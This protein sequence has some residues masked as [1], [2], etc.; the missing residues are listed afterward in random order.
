MKRRFTRVRFLLLALLS[1]VVLRAA[2]APQVDVAGGNDRWTQRVAHDWAPRTAAALAALQRV[3]AERYGVELSD[4]QLH[5]VLQATPHAVVPG[6]LG[7]AILVEAGLD[8][9]QLRELALLGPLRQD[10]QRLLTSLTDAQAQALAEQIVAGLNLPALPPYAAE[11]APGA[12]DAVATPTHV[13]VQMG[14]HVDDAFGR[15]IEQQWL[16]VVRQATGQFDRLV[17]DVLHVQLSRDVRVYVA[18]GEQ[19]YEQVLMDD[20]HLQRARAELTTEVSGGL[21]NN[22]GQ[23]ALK[24]TEKL[25]RPALYDRAVRVPLHELTHALQRQLGGMTYPG[26]KPPQWMIEGSADLMASMLARQV[27]IQDV[28]AE[29]LRDWRTR[30]LAWW[31]NGNRT[32]LR[33]DEMV[34]VTHTRW[35]AMMKAK[36]GCY[37]MAGL[38]TMYLQA[39]RGDRFLHDW[40]AYFR[41]AADPAQD[42]EGAFLQAFG[43]SEADFVEDFRRWLAQQ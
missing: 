10:I 19:D 27:R 36:R 11:S 6:G 12:S 35:L 7:P 40:V 8:E 17:G 37:Q 26:F 14:G 3:A 16:G 13:Q 29:T 42:A 5:L 1:A 9:A 21:S 31:H 43:M 2:G 28:E 34:G 25:K 22:R 20:M 23:I 39:I 15:E 24:F 38:M 18:A 30:N 32:D 4:S 33:P 41:S